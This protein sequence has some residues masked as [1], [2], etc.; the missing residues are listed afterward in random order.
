MTKKLTHAMVDLETLSQ[1]GNAVI[2]S[3]GAVAFDP[4]GGVGEKFYVEINV[5]SC[6]DA[7][8][9]I[10]KNTLD[11]WMR[12]D[13]E[14]RK[15]LV[16]AQKSDVTIEQAVKEFHAWW[17]ENGLKKIWGN[18]AGFDE[19]ILANAFRAVGYE[20][21]DIPWKFWDTW[22]VRTI[23]MLFSGYKPKRQGVYHNALDDALWQVE[24]MQAIFAGEDS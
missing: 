14:A 2:M 12:Q 19:P 3:I 4:D 21:S 20:R 8:L 5:Q 6:V 16:D 22:C 11:W 1:D 24:W 13:P 7:G 15:I 9:T 18:G 10:D 23:G 17:T